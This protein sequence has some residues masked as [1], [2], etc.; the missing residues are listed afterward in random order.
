[1]PPSSGASDP[2]MTVTSGPAFRTRPQGLS[3]LL[4]H[5]ACLYRRPRSFCYPKEH[6][7]LNRP[8]PR[9]HLLPLP[10]A[11]HPRL[12]WGGREARG[13][14]HSP[15]EPVQGGGPPEPA[16]LPHVPQLWAWPHPDLPR[17]LLS[18][19]TSP[20]LHVLVPSRGKAGALHPPEERL[21]SGEAWGWGW[22]TPARGSPPSL[23]RAPILWVER[24]MTLWAIQVSGGHGSGWA[25]LSPRPTQ[26]ARLLGHR[27]HHKLP[28]D[29]APHLPQLQSESP[30]L[31]LA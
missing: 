16:A 28:G 8:C 6:R 3:H 26:T 29:D 25:L 19:G 11:P 15:R 4:P 13:S 21:G 17:G 23:P 1:M 22:G 12:D 27:G 5:S 7:R 14:S 20:S 10:G 18:W 31:R 30:P 24:K 9:P 2:R